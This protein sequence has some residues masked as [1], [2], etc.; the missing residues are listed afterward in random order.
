[1]SLIQER[2]M[3]NYRF[4]LVERRYGGGFI[5]ALIGRTQ[6]WA[7]LTRNIDSADSDLAKLSDGVL[8]SLSTLHG[9]GPTVES[10]SYELEVYLREFTYPE[11]DVEIQRV[12]INQAILEYYACHTSIKLPPRIPDDLQLRVKNWRRR[13]F[14][15]TKVTEFVRG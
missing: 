2:I 7:E 10:A 9:C 5:A 1:M 12:E 4:V 14:E 6:M 8:T 15:S 3:N 11:S 13:F